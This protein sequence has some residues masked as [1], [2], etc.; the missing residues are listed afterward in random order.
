M[1]ERVFTE[2]INLLSGYQIMLFAAQCMFVFPAK[3]RRGGKI[4]FSL[5]SVAYLMLPRVWNYCTGAEFWVWDRLLVGGWYFAS[6]LLYWLLLLVLFYCSFRLSKREILFFG[7][8]AYSVQNFHSNLSTLVRHFV[9]NDVRSTPS[10]VVALVMAAILFLLLYHVLIGPQKREGCDNIRNP[11]IILFIFSVILLVN[12]Y[13][14]YWNASMT[15]A[16]NYDEVNLYCTVY[17]LI[18]NVLLIFVQFNIF[19]QTKREKEF[20]VIDEL[21]RQ[22]ERQRQTSQENRELINRKC[23]DLKHQ[24]SAMR[25]MGDL[26]EREQYIAE[27]E[28]GVMFY[29]ANTKTG[30][31]TLDVVLTEKWLNCERNRILFTYMVDGSD[32]DFM[33]KVDI[34]CLFGNALDNAIEYLRQVEDVEKRVITMSAAHQGDL[35]SLK[36]ENY[37]EKDIEFVDGL[38]A[39]SKKDKAYHGIGL[40]SIRYIVE[41]YGGNIVISREGDRFI[42]SILFFLRNK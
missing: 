4:G 9:F 35:L 16:G 29:N 38:P 40:K 14:Q 1:A 31:D 19:E 13:S 28:R 37:C 17:A 36:I 27:I 42:L 21:L 23:H 24:I 33:D 26:S 7:C 12:V 2:I 25:T 30:N 8:A 20:L 5:C 11:R 32:F 15:L 6:Y 3:F 22:S 10:R 39:T 41:K 18:C 34:Y